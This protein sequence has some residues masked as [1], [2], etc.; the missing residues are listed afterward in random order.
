MEA[1]DEPPPT[2][3]A[4]RADHHDEAREQNPRLERLRGGLQHGYGERRTEGSF[5]RAEAGGDAAFSRD[6]ARGRL[7]YQERRLRA[8]PGGA[9][10]IAN[11]GQY[12]QRLWRSWRLALR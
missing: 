4:E 2:A 7:Q 3:G 5:G 6:H 10:T 1:W 11:H 9:E 8:A 12:A